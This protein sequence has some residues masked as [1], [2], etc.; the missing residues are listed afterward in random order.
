MAR[1]RMS[2]WEG[3]HPLDTEEQMSLMAK[4]AVGKQVKYKD[5]VS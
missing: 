5:L 1:G 4:S 2:L 3:L